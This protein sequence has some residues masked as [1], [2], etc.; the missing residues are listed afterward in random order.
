MIRQRGTFT[1]LIHAQAGRTQCTS[2][3]F[4]V[5][6]T[7][8]NRMNSED[9]QKKFGDDYVVDDYTF[10]MGIDLRLHHISRSVSKIYLF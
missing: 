5:R 4:C 8:R 1:S 3:E 9:I 10:I 6:H 7:K 2:P